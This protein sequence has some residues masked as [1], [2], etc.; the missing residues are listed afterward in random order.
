MTTLNKKMDP[1]ATK[2]LGFL[3]A[4]GLLWTNQDL[5]PYLGK[6]KIT[7]V[8]WTAQNVEPRV[9]EVLPAAMIHFPKTFIGTVHLPNQ[10]QV[11]IENIKKNHFNPTDQWMGFPLKKMAKWANQPL[12]DKRTVRLS[13]KKKN[14]TF[15]FSPMAEKTLKAKAKTA[16]LTQTDFLEQLI[17]QKH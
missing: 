17:F 4:K 10:I 9:Y 6:L 15:S 8:L 16:N 11:I 12:K 1:R 13:E 3:V 14:K 2:T 7:D 5:K